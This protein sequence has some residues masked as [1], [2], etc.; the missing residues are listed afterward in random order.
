MEPRDW[1]LVITMVVTCK[2]VKICLRTG[3]PRPSQSNQGL[4]PL[5]SVQPKINITQWGHDP[6]PHHTAPII[7][8]SQG[9]THT[10]LKTFIGLAESCW[11]KR[12]F[13]LLCYNTRNFNPWA[14][15]KEMATNQ[16]L[17]PPAK[18]RS[19]DHAESTSRVHRQHLFNGARDVWTHLR[20]FISAVPPRSFSSVLPRSIVWWS[21]VYGKYRIRYDD[22]RREI[23]LST[24]YRQMD[25]EDFAGS[26]YYIF[27]IVRNRNRNN[28]HNRGLP[29]LL[30][31]CGRKDFVILQR[32]H[33]LSL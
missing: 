33:F 13:G 21:W 6:H 7:A 22:T 17:Y 30:A 5:S 11:W 29:K 23:R 3:T 24:R 14:R 28:D 4:P 32:T 31:T 15:E 16:P 26:P 10:L 20:P 2:S 27:A 9:C 12:G 19:S 25:E 1:L 18:R 8:V